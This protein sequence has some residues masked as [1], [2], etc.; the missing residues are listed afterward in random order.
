MVRKLFALVVVAAT[1][2]LIPPVAASAQPVDYGGC[3]IFVNP[4]QL[5]PGAE[6]L[7]TGTGLQPGVPQDLV[8]DEGL[9]SEQVL[10]TVTPDAA[11]AFSLPV[12]LPLEILLG[13]HNLFLLCGGGGGG[14]TSTGVDVVS[15]ASTTTTTV[16]VAAAGR[17]PRTGSD[18]GPQ[19]LA[20]VAAVVVGAG[21]VVASRRRKAALAAG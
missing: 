21:L 9:P 18:V 7:V 15:P 6:A 3:M 16:V 17:V 2:W 20:G 19:A 12:T 14:G 4:L 11:G 8:L 10:A 13:L 5:L 1:A